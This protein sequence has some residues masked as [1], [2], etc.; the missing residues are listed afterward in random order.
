LSAEVAGSVKKK[1]EPFPGSDSTQMRPPW[2]STIWSR[3]IAVAGRI[4]SFTY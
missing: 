4:R 1:V 2:R 3:I